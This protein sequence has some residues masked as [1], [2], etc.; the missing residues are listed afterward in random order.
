MTAAVKRLMIMFLGERNRA[1]D[2]LVSTE[3]QVFMSMT[4]SVE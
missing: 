2:A 1:S 4:K 3:K